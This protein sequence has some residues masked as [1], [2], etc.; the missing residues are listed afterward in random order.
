[1]NKKTVKI[2]ITETDDNYEIHTKCNPAINVLE[3]VTCASNFINIAFEGL[4]PL[5]RAVLAG[6]LKR[7]IDEKA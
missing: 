3:A 6:E 7:R 4:P 1:M 5:A 2:V